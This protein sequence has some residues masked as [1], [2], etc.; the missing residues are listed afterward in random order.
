MARL[1]AEIQG[2]SFVLVGDFNPKIFHP[3]WF[4][5]HG[6]IGEHESE[7]A[8]IEVVHSDVSVFSLE[9]MR[10]QV[11]RD[12]FDLSTSQEPFFEVIRDLV[13]GSFQLL[14]HTPVKAL[15]I[16][17]QAHFKMESEEKWH[18]LG[19]RLAPKESWNKI[20]KN[21]GMQ[22][23]A[24]KGERPD[25]FKGNILVNVEPSSKIKHGVYFAVNDHYEVD[26][27]EGE[28]GLKSLI[29]IIK[30]NWADSIERSTSIP[31]VVLEE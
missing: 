26:T 31:M 8:K 2:L 20:L 18:A 7:E 23:V 9:W 30:Q 4:S 5:H 29:E 3:L 15:G 22:R 25:G 28:T 13:I 14:E 16:N 27:G 10:L 6:L 21:P 17:Y 11:T 24:I 1:R 12:R 19:H